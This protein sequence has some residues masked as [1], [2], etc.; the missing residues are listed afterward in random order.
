MSYI[1]EKITHPSTI[2]SPSGTT[3]GSSIGI[4]GDAGPP[5][6]DAAANRFSSPTVLSSITVVPSVF[7]FTSCWREGSGMKASSLSGL[8]SSPSKLLTYFLFI[9]LLGIQRYIMSSS[10]GDNCSLEGGVKGADIWGGDEY[11][12]TDCWCWCY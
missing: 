2:P 1:S 8:V 3:L 11:W 7:T 10:F 5:S 9:S 12:I 6:P 4:A